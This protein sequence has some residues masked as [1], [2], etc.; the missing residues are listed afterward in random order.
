V[1]AAEVRT[2]ASRT[3]TSTDEISALIE[4][5]SSKVT[6]SVTSM[7]GLVGQ[8][9][10][11]QAQSQ[12]TIE[13][14]KEINQEVE[15]TASSNEQVLDYNSRQTYQV[16]QLSVQFQELFTELQSNANK[17][18]STSLVAESLYQNAEYLRKSVSNYTVRSQTSLHSG[19]ELRV[20]PRLKSTISAK[21]RLQCAREINALIDDI[22]RSGCK[23]ITK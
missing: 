16:E 13:S 4:D 17:A 11:I 15:N 18:D 8:V 3:A 14:F 12:T 7:A 22:S 9:N 5:F 6:N 10:T 21:L 2:L 1:V 20:E 23:I 19:A